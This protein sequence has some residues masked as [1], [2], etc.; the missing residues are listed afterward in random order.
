MPFEA[1]KSNRSLDF[2][3]SSKFLRASFLF[4]KA[5]KWSW[6]SIVI[7]GFTSNLLV[8][9][10]LDFKYQ[11]PLVSL[12]LE[13]TING[14]IAALVL[15]TCTRW[16]T[17][18]LNKQAPWEEG[19]KKR[20]MLQ[21][22]SVF[23]LIIV[24][25]NTLLIS[26]TYFFY[27]GFYAFGDLLIINVTV[28]TLTLFFSFIDISI[29][30]FNASKEVG[31][32]YKPAKE[33]Q[34]K[35]I[36]ISLGKVRHLVQQNDIQYVMSKS[37][38]AFVNTLDNRSLPYTASLDSLMKL[39][40]PLSFFRANRQT[41]LTHKVVKSMKSM[42]HGKIEVVLTSIDDKPKDPIIISRSRAASFRQWMKVQ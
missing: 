28:V 19:A 4:K 40:N 27:G 29:Y 23:M 31:P 8:N 21:L 25:L 2:S 37:K 34:E 14:V 32:A 16:L 33:F 35:P 36:E 6:L 39:L 10:I 18:K 12:S 22:A 26:V 9:V 13:E 41:V 1:S 30:F 17:R 7:L 5:F 24:V 38:M 15:L 3:N 11:R 20:L 42:D